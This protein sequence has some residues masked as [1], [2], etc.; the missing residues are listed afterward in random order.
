[1]D[2][3][4]RYILEAV[5]RASRP[6]TAANKTM[7]ESVQA[8]S[9]AVQQAGRTATTTATQTANA[10]R[11]TT[12]S[13]RQVSQA[14]DKVA[15]SAKRSTA[16]EK[17]SARAMQHAGQQASRQVSHIDRLTAAYRRL[18]TA[19]TDAGRKA[20]GATK[21][22]AAGATRVPGATAV[23][24]G[25]AAAGIGLGA[26]VASGVGFERQMKRVQAVASATNAELGSMTNLAMKLGA[27]TQFSAKQAADA[28]YQLSTAG[29]DANQSMKIL[30]G[31]LD[32]AAASGIELANAAEIQASAIRGFGLAASDA[33]RVA[34]ILAKTVNTSAVE[35]Y[36]LQESLKYIAPVAKASGQ[37]I[38]DMMA[39]VGLM[40]N[41]GIK[42]SQAGTTLRT[43][44]VRLANPTEKARVA[45]KSL[46][47]EAG[48]LAGPKGLL[49]LPNIMGKIVTGSQD[50]S[51]NT[52]NAALASIF[53]REALSGM[54]AMVEAGPEAFRKQS[55]A[56]TDAEGTARRTARVMRDSVAGAW[57]NFT[58]SVETASIRLTKTFLPAIKDVLNSGA[59]GVNDL[60]KGITSGDA[61]PRRTRER[62][63][64]GALRGPAAG[65]EQQQVS[66]AQKV[67]ATIR[68]VIAGAISFVAKAVPVAVAAI[69]RVLDAF[70]PMQPFLSNVLLPLLKGV[71]QGIIGGIV[72]AF[73]LAIPV[74]KAISTVLGFIGKAAAPLKPVFEGIGTVIGFVFGGPF[75]K[76]ISLVGK[77]GGVFRLLGAP[78]RAAAGLVGTVGKVFA[79]VFGKLAG[80]ASQAVGK[81][82]SVF[83]G[84]AHRIANA[85][86]GKLG[87]LANFFKNVGSAIV[88]AIGS[89]IAAAGDFIW[90]KLK[91]AAGKAGS[92]LGDAVGF[93]TRK[94]TGGRVWRYQ[95]GGM[96][97]ALVSPGENLHYPTGQVATVPG[98]RVAADN[99]FAMLPAGTAVVTGHGQSLMAQGASLGEALARQLP[100]FKAGGVVSG[101]YTSTAYG[102]PWNKM[103]GTGTTKTG[104]NLKGRPH[105]YGIAV[106]PRYIPLHSHVKVNPNPF[107]H[108]GTFRAFDIG[109]AIKG[110]RIDFYDWRGRKSQMAWGRRQVT[111]SAAG[112]PSR[113]SGSGTSA[114]AKRVIDLKSMSA[115]DAHRMRYRLLRPYGG[116]PFFRGYEA[117]LAGTSLRE[118]DLL[119]ELI[120]G[121]RIPFRD[122][123]QSTSG[124]P[125]TSASTSSWSKHGTM[126][127][128]RD[129]AT[130]HALRITSSFR[131][132]AQN[133]AAGGVEGSYHTKGTKRNPHAFDF[134]P[135]KQTALTAAKRMTPRPA[136]AM[137]H[138]AGSGM[139]LHVGLFRKGGIA[140]YRLGGWT[141]PGE[142]GSQ[143]KRAGV[144]TQVREMSTMGPRED[145]TIAMRRLV[146]SLADV[147]R[148]SAKQLV[149]LTN[150][151]RSQIAALIKGGVT[152]EEQVQ[153]RRLRAA[154]GAVQ[155]EAGRRV[156]TIVRGVQRQAEALTRSRTDLTRTL[157]IRG[158]DEAS[159]AGQYALAGFQ[160]AAIEQ[161]KGMEAKLLQARQRAK[162]NKAAIAAIDAELQTVRDGMADAFVEMVVAMRQA[163]MAA[164]QETVDAQQ[165]Q[166]ARATGLQE[167]QN[168]TQ[169]VVGTAGTPHGMREQAATITGAVVPQLQGLVAAL[170]LKQQTALEQGD[171]AAAE[172]T[173]N[174]I[175]GVQAQIMN[176]VADAADLLK[177]AAKAQ[178]QAAV[179]AAQHVTAMGSI[180]LQG[181]ELRQQ[182][183]GTF[184]SAGGRAERAAYIKSTILPALNA[185]LAPL[186]AAVDAATTPEERASAQEALATKTNEILQAQLEAQNLIVENTDPLKQITGS[187]AF[188]FGGD[189]WTDALGVGVGA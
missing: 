82:A 8:T 28:M 141:M 59:G 187:T 102:P 77:L 12:T 22:A 112:G 109:G 144:F 11:R 177:E 41:V 74:I 93:V 84:M 89:A 158:I 166:V 68:N 137:I 26:A 21:G 185:E 117:G 153:L 151:I 51:K 101:A 155:G 44:M 5:D 92:L 100:H 80:L 75:L 60:I 97:P 36:D 118:T 15:A 46:G 91:G 120:T 161:M 111:V 35:M 67:G 134:V 140:G 83:G 135:P 162:G 181:L 108:T 18:A 94:R 30:P 45:L 32:L 50:V 154:L 25:A 125:A 132:P 138:D 110:R 42:G 56:L 113:E 149:D 170:A 172:S 88:R 129:F 40:G 143:S 64:G 130:K 189:I 9:K 106:D 103:N 156:G 121:A 29:F 116:D 131:T 128:A 19:S 31:T 104:V 98:P 76:A 183:A 6:V 58:G 136:E 165:I 49:S 105:I 186:Q 127:W 175:L 171:F 10:A 96:V 63:G 145:P 38:E 14:H 147:R 2:L 164:A 4:Y 95:G 57:D 188:A 178:A 90:D 146:D 182:L 150:R 43:A 173:V 160:A 85:I 47:L 184:D 114:G 24:G 176:A 126:R 79:S 78:I 148:V 52:R 163:A 122:L 71:A 73:N 69:K 66:T 124:G 55:K 167:L 142:G 87:D 115:R 37:S 23:A 48:D 86:R 139:H 61:A 119:Q 17:E 152:Q 1:M 33:G 7:R 16:A 70:K 62:V 174:E 99:V 39:A 81:I 179:N 34:D 168:A 3:H 20:A 107:G 133:K 53:G 169:R 180:G 65:S 72:V 123:Q 13:Y 157:T 159:S 54:V 27:E